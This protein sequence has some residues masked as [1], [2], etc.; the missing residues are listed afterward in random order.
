MQQTCV[1]PNIH[2][3][4]YSWIKAC[5][6]YSNYLR[7][8]VCDWE[9]D[10]KTEKNDLCGKNRRQELMLIRSQWSTK[11]VLPDLCGRAINTHPCERLIPQPRGPGWRSW[12]P[13]KFSLSLFPSFY[14]ALCVCVYISLV[15]SLTARDKFG[16]IDV[17]LP[18]HSIFTLRSKGANSQREREMGGRSQGMRALV[19]LFGFTFTTV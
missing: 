16:C 8:T 12:H 5:L 4:A 11:V 7:F 19:F 2:T 17:I 6:P 18:A 1:D 14:L 10:N 13:R 9:S 15:H 3:H